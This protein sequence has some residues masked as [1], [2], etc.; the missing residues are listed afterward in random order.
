MPATRTLRVNELIQRELSGLLRHNYKEEAAIITI[1]GVEVA[2]DLAAGRVF[3]AVTGD[4]AVV[5]N[6]LKWLRARARELRAELSHRLV[7]RHMP[8]LTYELDTATARGNHVLHL[9]DE[10]ARQ[11]PAAPVPTPDVPP[12][13]AP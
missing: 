11:T 9:L 10:I 6:R 4:E 5:E 2:P 7:L 12:P 8:V 3:V 1:L 13:A